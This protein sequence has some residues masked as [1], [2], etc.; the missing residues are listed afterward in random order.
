MER[1]LLG[2][3]KLYYIQYIGNEIA[4]RRALG[5]PKRGKMVDSII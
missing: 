1:K 2:N 5:N 3:N 4:G